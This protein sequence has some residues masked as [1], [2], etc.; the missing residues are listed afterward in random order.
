[1]MHIKSD[2]LNKENALKRKWKEVSEINLKMGPLKST[3]E[4]V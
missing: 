3:K 4:R 1:M 2:I